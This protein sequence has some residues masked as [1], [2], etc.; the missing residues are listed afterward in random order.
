[1]TKILV[2]GAAGFIG[3]HTVDLLLAEGHEVTGLDNFRTGR[4]ENLAAAFGHPR[5]KLIRADA[6]EP[7][8]LAHILAEDKP[9]AVLHLAALVSVPESIAQPGLNRRLNIEM[10]GLLAQAAVTAPGVRRLVLAS[11]AA[12][13]GACPDL[14][15]REE[16]AGR[17]L[18]PYGA[19]KLASEH[20][21][22]RAVLAQPGLSAL[23]LRYFNVYG[24]RQDPRS[25]YS[26]V[27]SLFAAALREG[28]A[29][30]I[31]GD[32]GQTRDFIAVADVARANLLALTRPLSGFHVLNVCTGRAVSLQEL[33][34]A[35]GQALGA[36]VQPA[37]APARVGDI[38]HSLGFPGR[39]E[40]LLG[41]RAG[42]DL[43]SGLARLLRD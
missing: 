40:S 39:A 9:E 28:R 11:S 23:A 22:G 43:T 19:A 26:G 17:P 13:Y 27:I 6:A 12:V 29:P 5:F 37:R 32:G 25:P 2:T 21:L 15:L 7:G 30:A 20:I 31:H 14:P 16:S 8:V 24:P 41:F 42:G 10:T 3:S 1:M 18:S 34:A 38:R 35:M 33:L 36:A 4:E